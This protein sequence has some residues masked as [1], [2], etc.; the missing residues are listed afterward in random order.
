MRD[1]SG[2]QVTD[3]DVCRGRMQEQLVRGKDDI[4]LGREYDAL[5]AL[6]KGPLELQR[7]KVSDRRPPSNICI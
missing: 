3:G 2:V 1:V 6:L 4:S 7:Q 5:R